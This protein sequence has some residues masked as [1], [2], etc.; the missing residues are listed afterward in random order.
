MEMTLVVI[1]P[2]NNL[3]SMIVRR[4]FVDNGLEIVSA[5]RLTMTVEE[6]SNLYFD[7]VGTYFFKEILEYLTS[8]KSLVWVVSGDNA[9]RKVLDIKGKGGKTGIRGAFAKD[10]VQ[11]IMHSSD[12]VEDAKREVS[13]FW[14]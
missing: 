4:L 1:K 11:N 5:K 2:R 7:K 6:V 9:V 10:R 3:K 14:G 8:D 13:I 12:T